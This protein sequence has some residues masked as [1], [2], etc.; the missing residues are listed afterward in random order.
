MLLTVDRFEFTEKSTI[1]RLLIDGEFFCYTLED[2]DRKL[3][4]GG[5]KV[6]GETCIPRGLY[7]VSTRPSPKFGWV[8]WIISVPQFEWV[9][10]H[11]GNKPE[12]TEGCILVGDSYT[13]DWISHSRATFN[14]L[15]VKIEAA[16]DAG[17]FI[18]IEVV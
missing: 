17:D 5:E 16:I 11:W 1:G 6:Y 2:K 18:E 7:T 15:M 14:K 8:P 4:D 3:E 10:M 13:T 12:D 9:L